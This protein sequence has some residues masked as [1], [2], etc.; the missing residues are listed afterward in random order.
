MN[1]LAISNL[2]WQGEDE[3]VYLDLLRQLGVTCLEL[4]PGLVFGS[5]PYDATTEQK[6][7]YRQRLVEQQFS[8]IGLQSIFFGFPDIQLLATGKGQDKLLNLSKRIIELCAEL[9]G[10]SMV[11]GAPKNRVRGNLPMSEAMK[12]A[13]DN[14]HKMGEI[15]LRYNTYFTIEALP[16]SLGCDFI[17]NLF[18]ADQLIKN[19]DTLGVR[20]HIDLGAAS[21][22]LENQFHV[23]GKLSHVH[24]NDFLML[25]PTRSEHH[26]KWAEV[27]RDCYNGIYSIEMKKV[28]VNNLKNVQAAIEVTR[29]IYL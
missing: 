26:K 18:E 8:V 15:A 2:A 10:Q 21:L 13:S 5:N 1:Q 7:K 22:E 23:P 27:L 28:A 19:C 25:A 24:V 12:I 16:A 11:I 29:E 20:G 3:Q 17:N 4:A 6:Q 9:G 14:L